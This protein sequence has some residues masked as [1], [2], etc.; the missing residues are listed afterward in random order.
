MIMV[1]IMVMDDHH[2]VLSHHVW[3]SHFSMGIFASS[4]KVGIAG[5]SE[6]TVA[7]AT[8]KLFMGFLRLIEIMRQTL[9]AKEMNIESI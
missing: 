4:A 8:T 3:L 9:T 2:V 1:V 7:S 6:T 5:P